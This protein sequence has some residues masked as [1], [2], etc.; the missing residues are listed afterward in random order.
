MI[1]PGAGLRAD[2]AGGKRSSGTL[3]HSHDLRRLVS[4]WTVAVD[5]LA[6]AS[7]VAVSAGGERE[8]QA[9]I[10]AA[11]K[12][13]FADWAVADF[14]F[15]GPRVRRVVAARA[16]DQALAGAL[17][18][19]SP[20]DCPLVRSAVRRCTPEV[21]AP[22]DD[23]WL[24]GGLPDGRPVVGALGVCSV[25]VGPIVA[26]GA[27]TGAL[28][29]ARCADRPFIGFPE[30]GVLAHIAELTGAAVRRLRGR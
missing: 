21:R 4:A 30:L 10:A 27:A 26:Q 1:E 28:T 19:V 24:L 9:G 14:F 23:E 17:S 20:D 13:S 15:G 18:E 5:T 16:P 6:S 2:W 7:A 11:L 25:A 8:L 22:V 3:E 29:I 12:G